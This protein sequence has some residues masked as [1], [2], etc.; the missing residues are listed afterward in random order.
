MN[1]PRLQLLPGLGPENLD[2][3]VFPGANLDSVAIQHLEFHQLEMDQ[4]RILQPVI[5]AQILDVRHQ[6][7][8]K[9]RGCRHAFGKPLIAA[10]LIHV[11]HQ[12]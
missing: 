1:P 8:Y 3:P 5:T 12:L 2:L 10:A 9:S 11:P 6:L 4:F 7:R